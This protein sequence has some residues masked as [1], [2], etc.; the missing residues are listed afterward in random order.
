MQCSFYSELQW[1]FDRVGQRIRMTDKTAP[2]IT[3]IWDIWHI[4]RQQTSH[5]S[6]VFHEVEDC[7]LGEQDFRYLII[8]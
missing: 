5:C 3:K 8:L 1:S 7:A 4:I 6:S 2:A